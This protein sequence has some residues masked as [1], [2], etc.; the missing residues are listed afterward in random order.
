MT[1]GDVIVWIVKSF[2]LCNSF[3]YNKSWGRSIL[4]DYHY[5]YKA[6]GPDL[7]IFIENG[8]VKE[9]PASTCTSTRSSSSGIH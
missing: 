5:I 9:L 4:S 7:N 8:A 6:R 3:V 2:L 1:D